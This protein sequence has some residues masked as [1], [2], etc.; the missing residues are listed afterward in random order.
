MEPQRIEVHIQL[1]LLF[2]L[3]TA[4]YL[5]ADGIHLNCCLLF[6]SLCLPSALLSKKPMPRGITKEKKSKHREA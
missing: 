1:I 3:S 5:Y 4:T 2:A 6:N